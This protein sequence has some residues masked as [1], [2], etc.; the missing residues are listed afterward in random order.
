[1]V[2]HSFSET[3]HVPPIHIVTCTCCRKVCTGEGFCRGDAMARLPC[4]SV[5]RLRRV[6]M[7]LPDYKELIRRHDRRYDLI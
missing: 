1:M 2:G 6:G 7:K 3:D 4:D 5:E